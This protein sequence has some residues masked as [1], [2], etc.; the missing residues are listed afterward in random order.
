M[1]LALATW[2]GAVRLRSDLQLRIVGWP[3][4]SRPMRVA[5]LWDFHTGSHSGDIARLNANLF[6]H[7]MAGARHLDGWQCRVGWLEPASCRWTS[8][9]RDA[10]VDPMLLVLGWT[11]SLATGSGC[12]S[13]HSA[14][15]APDGSTP[16]LLH[17]AASSPQRCTSRRCPRHKG[18]VNSSLTLRPRARLWARA[19]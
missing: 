8:L 17:H 18:T 4:W 5:F 10:I 13:S 9:G 11:S 14:R 1:L 7:R 2:F 12:V 6:W 16:A 3:Q 15:A 19:A